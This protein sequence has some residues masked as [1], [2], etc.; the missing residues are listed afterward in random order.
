M[1]GHQ[2]D[3]H[4]NCRQAI[5]MFRTKS[6]KD[7]MIS[8]NGCRKKRTR[9]PGAD[10]LIA[11]NS[12][13]ADS[14]NATV[15]LFSLF[16]FL[17][18]FCYFYPYDNKRES[19]LYINHFSWPIGRKLFEVDWQNPIWEFY[20]VAAR[21]TLWYFCDILSNITRLGKIIL[22]HNWIFFTPPN[23]CIKPKIN[24]SWSHIW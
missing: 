22:T 16:H 6:A 3:R 2:K 19:I 24:D 5:I 4:V 11:I 10:Q 17:P 12:P 9:H 13:T 18:K 14:V 8:Q 23:T 1:S 15:T 7:S 20:H 21:R